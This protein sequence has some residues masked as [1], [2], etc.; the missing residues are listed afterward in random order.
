VIADAALR[1]VLDF[2][3]YIERWFRGTTDPTGLPDRLRAF[4]PR[5]TYVDPDGRTASL[6]DL[7]TLF[8]AT[9]G[10]A[11]DITVTVHDLEVVEPTAS[12]VVLRYEERQPG[13]RRVSMALFVRR[14][15][16]PH[17]VAW[18]Y[19]QET[20]LPAEATVSVT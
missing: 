1:E 7:R 20:W 17:G 9:H 16:A 11:R 6:D 14:D 15:D 2:H 3:A 12:Q 18:R 10:H 4:D 8:G 13:T 19:L 5:F